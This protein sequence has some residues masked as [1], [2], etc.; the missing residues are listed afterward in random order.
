[1]FMNKGASYINLLF[2]LNIDRLNYQIQSKELEL[3]AESDPKLRDYLIT[4]ISQLRTSQQ[5]FMQQSVAAKSN[6][7]SGKLFLNLYVIHIDYFK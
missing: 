5:L 4:A 2:S 3:K 1:M 6:A 7:V